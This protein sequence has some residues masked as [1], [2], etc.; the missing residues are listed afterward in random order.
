MNPF[1][2]L[3]DFFRFLWEDTKKDL[4]F[5][6]DVSDGRRKLRM[7]RFEG[8]FFDGQFFFYVMMA[9]ILIVF[10]F[11]CGFALA[12]VHYESVCNEYIYENFLNN[13]RFFSELDSLVVFPVVNVSDEDVGG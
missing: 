10:G 9:V 2:P 3:L 6:R 4:E 7:P 13:S 8:K 1:R 12:S 11:G 5:V